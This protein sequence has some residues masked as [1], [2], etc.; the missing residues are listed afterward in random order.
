MKG[1]ESTICTFSKNRR[2]CQCDTLRVGIIATAQCFLIKYSK[3]VGR[4]RPTVLP[5]PPYAPFSQTASCG[6][7]E[8]LS[9]VVRLSSLPPNAGS[10]ARV[11][12]GTSNPNRRRLLTAWRSRSS[13][14]ISRTVSCACQ[15]C[16]PHIPIESVGAPHE[17][18]PKDA[19]A[20]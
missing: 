4:A 2:E 7:V 9:E 18:A 17:A 5:C 3:T 20:S 15:P 14:L 8:T 13:D 10:G 6:S 16:V 11:S 19:R 1:L 12:L